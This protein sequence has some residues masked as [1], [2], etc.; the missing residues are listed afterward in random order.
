MGTLKGLYARFFI[1]RD[2]M[3]TLLPESSGLLVALADGLNLL[4]KRLR[5]QSALVGEPILPSVWL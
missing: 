4:V 3:D 1:G 5:S 2:Q